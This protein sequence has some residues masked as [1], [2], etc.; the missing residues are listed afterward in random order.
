M[1]RLNPALHF[2]LLIYVTQKDLN[3][4][5]K[6]TNVQD[7]LIILGD[8]LYRLE[9]KYCGFSEETSKEDYSKWK[10]EQECESN[11]Q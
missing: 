10:Q 7:I 3:I 4:Q 5:G 9:S 2:A 8:I 11:V 6:K 1:K